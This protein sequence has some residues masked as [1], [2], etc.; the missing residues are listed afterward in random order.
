MTKPGV[1]LA[2][3][4]TLSLDAAPGLYAQASSTLRGQ[5]HDS[6]GVPVSGAQL[7]VAPLQ[8]ATSD[9]DGRFMVSDIPSGHHDIHVRGLGYYHMVFPAVEFPPRD[10]VYLAVELVHLPMRTTECMVSQECQPRP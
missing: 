2:I 6:S 1:C 9:S 8:V 10:T 4:L 3:V 7:I 5:V